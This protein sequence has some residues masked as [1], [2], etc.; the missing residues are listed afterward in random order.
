M[1]KETLTAEEQITSFLNDK[2]N[3]RYHYNHL[4]EEDYK[5][6][7]GSLNLDLAMDGGLGCGI[8]RLT[9]INEGGKTSCALAFA[10]HF[11]KHF[12]DKGKIIYFKAEGRLSKDMIKR[13]GVDTDERKW[14]VIA[15]NIFEKVFDLVRDLVQNNQEKRKYMFIIDSMDGMCRQSDYDKA[16]GDAEQVA[17][18]SLISSVFLKKQSLPIAMNGHIAIITS[19]VRI[20]IPTGYSRSGARPKQAGGHAV[21]HYANNI[22]E[23]E[24]RYNA[25]IFWENPNAETAEKKGNPTGHMCKIAFKKTVNEKTGAKVRYPVKYGRT[26]GNSIWVER[27]LIDMMKLWGYYE[28]SGA[29]IKFPED[30]YEKYKSIGLP[31]KI[32]G[33]P[34]LLALLEEN[35]KL[36]EKL[37]AEFKENILKSGV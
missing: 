15:C 1:S 31:E 23:F 5:I 13:T 17:G 26:D 25:D 36:S 3:K 4:K 14:C 11:Q 28:K 12:G 22:L 7:S 2:N 30:I 21:K 35:K 16:F 33:E 9:G 34:K 20:E 29:W 18:G 24:E 19:Q 37:I 27:E 32:Q 10:K 6:S 8:H